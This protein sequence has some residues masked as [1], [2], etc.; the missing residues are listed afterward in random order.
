MIL[1]FAS[2]RDA[3]QFV[4]IYAPIVEST[5]IS[6]ELVAPDLAE[7]RLRIASTPANKPW[8]VAEIDGAVAGYAYASTFRGRAA[9][10]F[11]VEVTAY[12][13]ERA[14]RNGVGRALYQSL[15]QLLTSQGYRRAF[16]GITLPNDAS[17]ALHR[18]A[19]FSEAGI[20]HAAGYKFDRWH[21]VAFYE[22][23]LGPLY[24][25]QRDPIAVDALAPA[26]VEAAFER[27]LA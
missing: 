12:V 27:S 1:R 22:C 8:I 11:G 24:D 23:A 7:M 26:Q 25:P 4:A 19:G 9:Y 20:V 5:A 15:R 16:A 6:F 2:L 13:A 3:E 21:D 17:V 14:R 18:A 10:R